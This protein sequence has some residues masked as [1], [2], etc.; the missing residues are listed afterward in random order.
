MPQPISGGLL[1]SY[2]CTAECRHCMY[3]CS[4]DWSSDWI[5]QDDMALILSELA[6]KIVASP[7]GADHVSINHGLHFTGGEPFMNF[8]LLFNGVQ[9]ANELEI[10]ST[11]VETNCFWCGNDEITREKLFLLKDSGLKGILISV[12]PF[13][14]EYVPFERSERCIRISQEVFGENVM[15]Y[16]PEYYQLF[17]RLGIKDRI[18]ME[19]C[20]QPTKKEDLADKIAIFLMGRAACRLKPYYASFPSEAFLEGS[21]CPAFL[22]DWHNHF[23]NYGNILPG[24]CGGISLG[25]WRNFD[26]LMREGIDLE[27]NPV[28]GFLLEEDI[29]GLFQFARDYGFRESSE[30]YVSKC[31]LCLQIRRHLHSVGDFEELV[32]HAFYEHLD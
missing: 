22:R 25:S 3:A 16:Q 23:D 29:L 31:E 19:N 12:N 20:L 9:I 28:L 5:P 17:K 4:P 1:L 2:K 7:Y 6:G 18:T 10:P 27:R 15:V 8:D 13:Y 21:C 26:I 11:F 24:Y 32:P 14:T 30:G